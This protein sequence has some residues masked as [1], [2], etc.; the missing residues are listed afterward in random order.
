MTEKKDIIRFDSR[1]KELI[2]SQQD[3][4][5]LYG[6]EKYGKVIRSFEYVLTEEGIKKAM[7]DLQMQKKT[8]EKDIDTFKKTIESA[9]NNLK[10]AEDNYKKIKSE[11]QKLKKAVGDRINFKEKKEK[12][13]DGRSGTGKGR[14]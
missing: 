4:V 13:Q 3:E 7:K 2:R 8:T 12:N 11:M 1:K 6:E 10:I 14:K 9:Q 5:N